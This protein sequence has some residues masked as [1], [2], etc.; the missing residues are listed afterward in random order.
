MKSTGVTLCNDVLNIHTRFIKW[1]P[2][3]FN[4]PVLELYVFMGV[5]LYSLLSV[6]VGLNEKCG[7]RENIF[8][9]C[10]VKCL[11]FMYS[12]YKDASLHFEYLIVI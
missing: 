1:P 8:L 6:Y 11:A 2:E 12:L 5:N 3:L 9:F 7:I 4:H 10:I